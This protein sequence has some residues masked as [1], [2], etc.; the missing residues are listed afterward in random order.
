M[1]LAR[2]N[3][4]G[5]VMI[6]LLFLLPGLRV[7][8]KEKLALT[9]IFSLSLLIIIVAIIRVVQ[10]SATTQ[11]VDPVWLALWSMIEASVGKIL[12]SA[13]K[14]ALFLMCDLAIIVA[15]LPSFRI[16]IT[17]RA[18]SACLHQPSTNGSSSRNRF[19]QFKNSAIRLDPIHQRGTSDL[20]NLTRDTSDPFTHGEHEEAPAKS[21]VVSSN[22]LSSS[23]SSILK[24]NIRVRNEF[25]GT[26]HPGLNLHG[27]VADY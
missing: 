26:M 10:T 24:S 6:P 4:L 18:K 23:E 25:V 16:L 19:S 12:L 2:S 5:K 7:N 22:K 27:Y 15:N 20:E 3:H 21:T 11:H 17:N 9:G 8:R 13:L 1:L 14:P